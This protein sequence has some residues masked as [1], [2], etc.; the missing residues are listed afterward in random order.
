M[1]LDDLKRF[2]LDQ[3]AGFEEL[4]IEH[5][6]Q[7]RCDSGEVFNYY[8]KRGRVVVQGRRTDLSAAVSTLVVSPAPPE[9][10]KPAG[11]P[12]GA[13]GPRPCPA[14]AVVAAADGSCLGNPG[15]GGWAWIT[16]DGQQASGTV[17]RTTNN[18]MELQA[19]LELLR[20]TDR[21]MPLV[22]QT[23]SQL[24][25]DI[26]TKWLEGWRRTG[27]L[28]RDGTDIQNVDLIE[29]VSAELANRKVEFEKVP[30]HAGHPLNEKADA[31]A[32]G[33][34]HRSIGR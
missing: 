10:S 9:L 15:P 11:K 31:L 5:G 28:R 30:G 14:G 26:F 25:I 2:L 21:A 32:K 19:V 20:A 13:T 29:A 17:A 12:T 16:E 8:P 1:T 7:L 33:A 18:R 4:A 22:I 3:G 34:A 23:D 24:T 27:R 6:V